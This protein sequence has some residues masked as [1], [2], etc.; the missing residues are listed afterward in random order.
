[1]GKIS[2]SFLISLLVIG[3][4]NRVQFPSQA[5]SA[6]T[7]AYTKIFLFWG[8]MGEGNYE[9]YSA[10]P[11]ENVYEINSHTNFLQGA[12]T[13]ASLGIYSPRTI[14]VVCAAPLDEEGVPQRPQRQPVKRRTPQK[15]QSMPLQKAPSMESGEHPKPFDLN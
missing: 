2:L 14:E 12:L 4:Y 5:P 9:L 7:V 11:S 15:P 1:M 3:C 10:C 6:T 13:V 8:L